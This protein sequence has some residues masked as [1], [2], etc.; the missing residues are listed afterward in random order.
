[1]EFSDKVK[2][3]EFKTPP[4]FV[5]KT[6]GDLKIRNNYNL[7]I[8]G[9]KHSETDIEFLLQAETEIKPNDILMVIGKMED[10]MKFQEKEKIS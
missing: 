5:G 1:M 6:I 9:I 8:I 2:Y 4:N 7:N 10:V 3:I